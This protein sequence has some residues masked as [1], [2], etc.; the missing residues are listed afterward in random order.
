MLLPRNIERHELIG[1]SIKITESKN[2]TLL[3]LEGKIIDET[4]NTITIQSKNSTKKII[5]NQI[6]MRIKINQKE[7]IID[8]NQLV[9]RPHERIK[10]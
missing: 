7:M 2:P 8:G 6:K 9:G 4:Q 10:K 5:K 3:G 1:L